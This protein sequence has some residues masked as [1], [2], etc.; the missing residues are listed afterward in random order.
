MYNGSVHS[1]N[2][3]FHK[4]NKSFSE[5][6][7]LATFVDHI[8]MFY[9]QHYLKSF[10]LYRHSTCLSSLKSKSTDIFDLHVQ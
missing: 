8:R 9:A 3:Y 5:Y 4:I 2:K 7:P 6:I 10:G 1:F